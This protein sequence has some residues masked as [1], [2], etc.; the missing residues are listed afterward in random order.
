VTIHGN[1]GVKVRGLWCDGPALHRDDRPGPSA[2]GGRHKGRWL[3]RSDPRDRRQVFF[4]DPKDHVWYLLRWTGLPPEGEVPAFA[5]TRVT[6]LLKEARARGLAPRSDAELLPLRL[7][8]IGGYIPVDAWPAKVTKRDRTDHAREILQA[9]AA[10]ADRPA[11][12][13]LPAHETVI[14]FPAPAG[15]VH[16]PGEG[17]DAGWR[18]RAGDVAAA[19]HRER[20][21]R[22]RDA[23]PQRAAQ[24]ARASTRRRS[25]FAVPREDADE[26]EDGQGPDPAG[27]TPG[28][29]ES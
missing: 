11:P 8:L 7:E 18:D 20:T 21:R 15:A 28:Q 9:R 26:A 16:A 4:Q 10:A 29:E 24:A 2:R 23:V 1:R 13:S 6:E 12:P 17:R 3:V 22:R 27:R 25:M 14:P 5:D 19:V